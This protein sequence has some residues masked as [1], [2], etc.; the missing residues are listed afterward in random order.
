MA[1]I[2]GVELNLV[3]GKVTVAMLPNFIPPTFNTCIVDALLNSYVANILQYTFAKYNY[4][5]YTFGYTVYINNIMYV[6]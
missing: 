4:H 1:G 5:Q 6:Q 2:I 3:V